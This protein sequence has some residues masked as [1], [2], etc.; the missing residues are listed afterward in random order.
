MRRAALDGTAWNVLLI[1]SAIRFWPRSRRSVLE[2]IDW[3]GVPF[4]EAHI[5][6]IN[7]FSPGATA[8]LQRRSSLSSLF[9][10]PGRITKVD[11]SQELESGVRIYGIEGV[12]GGFFSFRLRL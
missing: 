1:R 2:P 6:R 11:K 5:P 9:V 10:C 12:P 7:P 3:P 8:P 4:P